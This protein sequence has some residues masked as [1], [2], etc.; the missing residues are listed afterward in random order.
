M[1]KAQA[2]MAYRVSIKGMCINFM[3]FIIKGVLGIFI[4][5]VSLISDAVHSLS[6]IASTLVVLFGIKLSNKPAD[7]GHPYGH[8]KMECIIA[9]FLGLMLMVIGIAIAREGIRKITH[10]AYV[11]YNNTVLHIF[12]ALS[13]MLSI[14]AKEWM[15]RFTIKCARMIGSA[16]MA[17]DAWHHR[18]DAL[19]SIGSLIGIIGI[20]MGYPIIDGIACVIIA[21]FILKAAFDICADACGKLV[22]SAGS[23]AVIN[24]IQELVR[25]NREVLAID[26][27][28]TRQFGAKLYVDLEITLDR[29]IS[30]EHSHQIAHCLHD[31]IEANIAEVKHC[32]IHVNPS[33]DSN[34]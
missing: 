11:D 17:A 16:S 22:D 9:L 19:S 20:C 18:A 14:M 33:M 1:T 32:M 29:K 5:S 24:H 8:E 7:N 31:N 2:Q 34:V 15:Y 10:L 21:C 26:M 3:L 6:D 23:P 25:E 28:R 13:A 30:F 4:H 27:I 12:A